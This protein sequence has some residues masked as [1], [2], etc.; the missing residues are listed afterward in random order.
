[1]T[2]KAQEENFKI[3][4][5]NYNYDEIYQNLFSDKKIK[6][7]MKQNKKDKIEMS[8]SLK[9]IKDKLLKN[10]VKT[11]SNETNFNF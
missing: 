4:E 2:A 9:A 7:L 1:M 8:K 6:N 3:K 5:T 11:K 10:K